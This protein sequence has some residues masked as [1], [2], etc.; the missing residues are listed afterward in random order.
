MHHAPRATHHAPRT[1]ESQKQCP[2]A[3]LRKGGGQLKPIVE[4][5]QVKPKKY[6]QAPTHRLKFY[7]EAVIEFEAITTNNINAES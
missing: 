1:T 7:E 3:F 4:P 5:R 6:R 2:S